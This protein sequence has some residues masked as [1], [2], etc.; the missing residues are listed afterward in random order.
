M[1]PQKYTR[2]HI[3]HMLEIY[4]LNFNRINQELEESPLEKK[5]LVKNDTKNY[6]IL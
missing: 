6:K 4:V 2:M 3:R 5:I 1:K